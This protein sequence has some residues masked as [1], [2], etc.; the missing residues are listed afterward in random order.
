MARRDERGKRPEFT[1]RR[2]TAAGDGRNGRQRDAKRYEEEPGTARRE[3]GRRTEDRRNPETG[4]R[5]EAG[6]RP[7]TGR[8][9]EGGRR[10]EAGRRPENGRRFESG[11][12]PETGEPAY[13]GSPY[14]EEGEL[15][16]LE[17]RNSIREAYAAG[18]TIDKLFVLDGCMDEPVQRI[19]GYAKKAGTI[20]SF[21]TKDKLDAM[22]ETG[23]HQ[24]VIAQAAAAEYVEVE[25]MLE[26]ARQKGEDPF[27]I[28][29]DE[30]EDP[31]NLGAIIRTANAAGAHGVIIPKRHAATLTATV[32]KASAGAVH[33]TKIAKVTN[34]ASEIDS[35]KKKGIWV[36]CSAM[37]G[38]EMYDL[39]L[40]GPIALVIGNEGSGV[41]QLIRE[42]CDFTARIP[43]LG[44]IE[45]LNAS[46]A[47]GVLSYEIVRQ[48]RFR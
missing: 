2:K 35:L 39:D 37:D 19:L 18:R 6:R 14:G 32:A 11:R 10:P 48:R 21:V 17:G 33:F 34:L 41:R 36:L 28:L 7:E 8:R 15:T 22:S 12:R 3:A 16:R 24:G 5:S 23:A 4:R 26:D 42:K 46:V 1:D 31:H 29:L 38:K 30:I 27:L 44:K 20:V 47:A 40:T 45:S 43:L 25:E 13:S 9:Y